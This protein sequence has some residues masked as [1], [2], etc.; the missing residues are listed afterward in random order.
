MKKILALL[1]LLLASAAAHAI[2]TDD[3]KGD[4]TP[5]PEKSKAACIAS[6]RARL[7]KAKMDP[8]AI[9]KRIADESQGIERML[10]DKAMVTS[11]DGGRIGMLYGDNAQVTAYKVVKAET[12]ADKLVISAA[13]LS[14]K[15]EKVELAMTDGKYLTMTTAGS[16]FNWIV[17]QKSDGKES[18][19]DPKFT[20]PA[21]KD[22]DGLLPEDVV[23]KVA[24]LAA[25]GD[26]AG[27]KPFYSNEYLEKWVFEKTLKAAWDKHKFVMSFEGGKMTETDESKTLTVLKVGKCGLMARHP[28]V[29]A[30]SARFEAADGKKAGPWFSFYFRQVGGKWKIVAPF[31]YN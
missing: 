4:W 9:E 17:W 14:G 11:F 8:A 3:I 24:A 20:A 12:T 18:A 6:Y 13:G 29:Y 30:A 2:T 7:G 15:E 19:L 10:A 1:P 5:N 26:G 23:R 21:A 28:G 27:A 22:T 16:D 25:E 31:T